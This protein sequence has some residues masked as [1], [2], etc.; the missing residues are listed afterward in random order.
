MRRVVEDAVDDLL[1]LVEEMSKQAGD[2]DTIKRIL[3]ARNELSA[4][5][6]LRLTRI[7]LSAIQG[8]DLRSREDHCAPIPRRDHDAFKKWRSDQCTR[9]QP[10]G[11]PGVEAVHPR[12]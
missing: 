3:E 12:A 2:E 10:L 9:A 8:I 5:E 6:R 11:T 1:D 4:Q 7:A